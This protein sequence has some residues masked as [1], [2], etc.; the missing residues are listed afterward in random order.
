MPCLSRFLSLSPSVSLWSLSSSLCHCRFAD[1]DA[2]LFWFLW[3][4]M[5]SHTHSLTVSHA[6]THTQTFCVCRHL[7]STKLLP[8]PLLFFRHLLFH[9]KPA[10][11]FNK[12]S[13][14]ATHTQPVAESNSYLCCKPANQ[15]IDYLSITLVYDGDIRREYVEDTDK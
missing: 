3:Y 4:T 9:L 10:C 5:C 12:E 11:S 2:A 1:R 8:C 13:V 6:H 7:H 14:T 15:N